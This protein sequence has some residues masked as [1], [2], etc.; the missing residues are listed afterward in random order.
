MGELMTSDGNSVRPGGVDVALVLAMA[1]LLAIGL[2]MVYS[3]TYALGFRLYGNP[4]YFLIRQGLWGVVGTA[5]LLIMI[6]IH[7]TGWQRIS[8]LVMAGMLLILAV[9]LIFGAERFGGR[10]W[11]IGGSVQPSELAK[12]AVIIYIADWL[13][14][15]GEQ[16][17]DVTYG[18]IPFAILIG[19]VTG[20]ILLQPDF[21]TSMLIAT[22]AFAMFFVAGAEVKQLAISFLVGG[23]ALAI[24]ILQA[25]YRLNRI[26][27]FLD[28]MSDP[29]DDGYQIIQTLRALIRGGA[30]GQGLGNSR[31]KLGALPAAHTDAIFAVLGEELGLIGGLVVI[32]L[33][34]LLAYRGFQVAQGAPDTFGMLLA[35]GVTA[36]LAFQALINIAVVTSTIPFTGIPLPF[37]SF[38]GSSL[39]TS[40]AGVGLLLNISKYAA[41][42]RDSRTPVRRRDRGAR[43]PSPSRY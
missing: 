25:P 21:S 9:L 37:I 5:A 23:L 4:N 14:S 34:A 28:P 16:I 8:V 30:T 20:L 29:S 19:V 26:A 31:Q 39:V 24:L 27:V 13:S 18:L 3:T 41:T 17:R 1:T 10:R 11:F 35:S 42:E 43:L 2:I 38:G 40:M 7:Y 33:F 15:K 32:G 12:L 22:T 6:R 36:W